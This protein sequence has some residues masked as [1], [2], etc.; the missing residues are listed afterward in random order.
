M[1]KCITK[2]NCLTARAHR[3][4]FQQAFGTTECGD[5]WKSQSCGSGPRLQT[6]GNKA[7]PRA[8]FFA[9]CLQAMCEKLASGSAAFRVLADQIERGRS[10]G[11]CCQKAFGRIIA[12]LHTKWKHKCSCF[13]TKSPSGCHPSCISSAAKTWCNHRHLCM[14]TAVAPKRA[15][16]AAPLFLQR[17]GCRRCLYLLLPVDQ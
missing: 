10:K 13:P 3:H 9:N 2:S 14:P 4:S 6:E 11:F 7:M 15:Q 1:N 12:K 17:K 16:S 5:S 8:C